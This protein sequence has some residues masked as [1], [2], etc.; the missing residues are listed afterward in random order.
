VSGGGFFQVRQ[1]CPV[2]GGGGQMIT[3]PCRV[4]QGAGQV[5][6]RKRLTLKIPAG[7][8]TGARLRLAGRGESGMRGGPPGDL[9]V[10]MHVK[11][12]EL[13]ERQ[14]DDLLC[15]VP[16]P[17]D[18]A[19]LGG[20][21]DVPTL[22]GFARLKI[23]PGT[24][25]GKVFRLRDKGMP[26]L[27]SYGHGSLHVRVSLEVPVRLNSRQKKALRE[28]QEASEEESYPLAKRL[29]E[30]AQAFFDRRDA[31]KNR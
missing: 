10:V 21:V 14:G 4:C 22:D 7:V 29:K 6:T 3:D 9:Y 16:V 25:N 11:P 1:T 23:A 2:C 31:M 24:N 5:K 30:L 27:E 15:E 8:E 26:S 28:Y 13:F 12:H 17:F 19:A 18:V 20:E